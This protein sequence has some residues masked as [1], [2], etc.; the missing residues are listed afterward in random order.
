MR[1]KNG[2]NNIKGELRLCAFVK[3]NLNNKGIAPLLKL[4]VRGVETAGYSLRKRLKFQE[5]NFI[6]F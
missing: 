2:V 3:M 6:I 5:T 4:S 1:I